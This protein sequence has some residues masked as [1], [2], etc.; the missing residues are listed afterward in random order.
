MLKLFSKMNFSGGVENSRIK[1]KIKC[2]I[3]LGG[4][5]KKQVR[6][7]GQFTIAELLFQKSSFCQR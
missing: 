6:S 5:E 7:N 3:K 4:S 2:A 1:F